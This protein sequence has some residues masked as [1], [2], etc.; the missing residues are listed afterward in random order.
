MKKQVVVTKSFCDFCGEEASGHRSCSVCGKEFCYD[1]VEKEGKTYRQGVHFSSV[2]GLYCF[3]CD[4]TARE[5]GDK[6]HQA[7]RT[8]NALRREEDGFFQDFQDRKEK[9]E[10]ELK[11]LLGSRTEL[12]LQAFRG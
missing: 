2:D 1:C 4:K 5:T 9:A 6:L 11:D 7:Y 12:R 8:V 3:D 10:K